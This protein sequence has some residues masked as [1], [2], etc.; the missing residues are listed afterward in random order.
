MSFDAW[1]P[2]T[3][4]S[5]SVIAAVGL[6]WVLTPAPSHAYN[7]DA[8]V[9][10]WEANYQAT[11]IDLEGRI[12]DEH[13]L[14]IEDAQLTLIGWGDSLDNDGEGTSSWQ[15]GGFELL[16]LAR[17]NV[18]VSIEAPGYYPEIVTVEL[19]RPIDE[20][21]VDLGDVMLY[22]QRFDR[23]RLT[24]TGDVMFGRRMLDWDD[25]GVLG[26]PEDLLHMNTLTEDTAALFRFVQ[27]VL[28]ADDLT[29]INLETP[30]TDNLDTP[31]PVKSFVFNAYPES[32]AALPEVGVDMVTLGNNH[33]YDYLD[34]GTE[35]T[36][37]HLDA[38]GMPWV[39][40]GLTDLEA[41]ESWWATSVGNI[42]LALQGFGDMQGTSYGAPELYLTAANPDKSGA[43]WST[44][45]R[46]EQFVGDAI[47]ADRFAIPQFH[48]G[49]EYAP[50]QTAAMRTDFTAAIDAG[51]GIVIAHH[52]HVVHGISTYDGGQGPR[53]VIGSLGNF[54]FDQ[55]FYETFSSYIAS[56][57][58]EQGQNGVEV[59]R[60]RLIPIHLDGYVP[61]LLTGVGTAELG[62]HVAQLG[63]AEQLAGGFTRAVVFAEGSQLV[64][65]ANESDVSTTDLLNARNVAL[66]GG[67]T[68]PVAIEPF[69]NTDALTRI[70]TNVAA[71]CE[72]GV[73]RMQYGDFEDR[74]VDDVA[75]EGDRWSQT[76][77]RYIQRHTVRTGQA[78]AVLL[79]IS[80][81]STKTSLTTIERVPVTPTRKVSV[82]GWSKGVNGGKLEVQVRWKTS[83]GTTI[84]TTVSTVKPGGNWDWQSFAINAIAPAN[85]DT[86]E[87]T[88]LG[89]PPL[90]GESTVFLDDLQLIEW[91]VPA[92]V[93]NGGGTAITSPNGW[94]AVRCAAAGVSLG[95]TLTHRVY[96]TRVL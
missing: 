80:S 85:A 78:A 33:L 22:A 55:D 40:A 26:E 69:S 5:S 44:A 68:G 1:C 6:A 87:L 95:L 36:L 77:S 54:V 16:G 27:P 18:L 2:P 52:P 50:A 64:V 51:A 14:A 58:I 46:I 71:T 63:T 45:S 9:L 24:F 47:A 8:Q 79:R 4:F 48:G 92:L 43:L 82:T 25:D 60:L 73:D 35:D 34:V 65:A 29:S 57:D 53:F 91:D 59:A 12:I 76:T 28:E 37:F 30:V 67:T 74:D 20:D 83:G 23:V 19:Q 61:R 21:T 90:A 10:A 89:S 56:V 38:L 86:V 72:L 49:T 39:G 96:E 11:P 88:Y 75:A 70:A 94:D 15:G 42:D 3:W 93:V 7:F 66:S 41:R 32:A 31:H 17:A 81:N 13:G 84:S 62:R